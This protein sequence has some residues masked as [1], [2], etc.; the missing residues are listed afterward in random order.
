MKREG[1]F[2]SQINMPFMKKTSYWVRWVFQ[3]SKTTKI[4]YSFSSSS[5]LLVVSVIKR[6]Q[7]IFNAQTHA[8]L[9]VVH[10]HILNLII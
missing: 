5:I 8:F 7:S 3:K 4:L 1:I 9:L 2:M 10:I 6:C